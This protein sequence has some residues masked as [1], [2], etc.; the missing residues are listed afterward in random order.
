MPATI[1][2]YERK[3]PALLA[4]LGEASRRSGLAADTLEKM[5]HRGEFPP[6]RRISGRRYCSR[7][8][9]ERWLDDIATDLSG[10]AAA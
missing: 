6:V 2:T 9:L 7:S 10:A 5:S 1:R 4:P 8:A 3:P